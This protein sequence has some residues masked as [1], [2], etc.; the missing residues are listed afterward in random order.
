M[1]AKLIA[2]AESVVTDAQTNVVSFFNLIEELSAPNVPFAVSRITCVVL[3]ERL[4]VEPAIATVRLVARNNGVE[5]FSQI[6]NVNFQDKLR[7]RVLGIVGG[8]VVNAPGVVTFSAYDAAGA[9]LGEWAIMVAVA[10]PQVVVAA[11]A[12]A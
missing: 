8:M 9:L 1:N 10:A 11:P 7:T 2:C 3:L 4:Q 6:V 5:L 12:P